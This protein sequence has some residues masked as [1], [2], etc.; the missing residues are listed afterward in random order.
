MLVGAGLTACPPT[1]G[2]GEEV[3]GGFELGLE[4]N[5]IPIRDFNPENVIGHSSD[6]LNSRTNPNPSKFKI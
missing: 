3:E 4:P 6:R 1:K 2:R 5:S